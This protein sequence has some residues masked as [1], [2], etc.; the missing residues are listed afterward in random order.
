MRSD[1]VK[2]QSASQHIVW[3]QCQGFWSTEMYTPSPSVVI[4]CTSIEAKSF[5][6]KSSFLIVGH[7]DLSKEIFVSKFFPKSNTSNFSND[8][9]YNDSIL[10]KRF[11]RTSSTLSEALRFRTF[12]KVVNE[13]FDK[14]IRSSTLKSR[15]YSKGK[16]CNLFS[17][18]S[19]MISVSATGW[20][21]GAIDNWQLLMLKIRN[22]GRSFNAEELR[23]S[24]EARTTYTSWNIYIYIYMI[25]D[26]LAVIEMKSIKKI[27]QFA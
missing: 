18:M 5:L 26:Y 2:W 25:Y 9:Q 13:F 1:G 10:I 12:G 16:Y 15:K 3:S 22:R 14:L 7:L 8:A 23:F 20:M 11:P 24:W 17:P 27:L 6:S 4:P 21:D 19:N